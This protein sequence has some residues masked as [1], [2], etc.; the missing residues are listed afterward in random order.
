MGTSS[1]ISLTLVSNNNDSTPRILLNQLRIT[2]L[3]T[4]ALSINNERNYQE[5]KRER[6]KER[7]TRAQPKARLRLKESKRERGRTLKKAH[8]TP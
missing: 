4:H 3:H 5:L 8:V 2:L 7:D 6:E 1:L